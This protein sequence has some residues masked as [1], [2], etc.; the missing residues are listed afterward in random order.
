MSSFSPGS[1][2]VEAREH[3]RVLVDGVLAK[4]RAGVLP[5]LAERE[6]VDCKEEAGRRGRGGSLLVGEPHNQE[7]ARQLANEVTCMANTPGG[8]ALLVGVEDRTGQLLGAGLDAEWLRHRVYEHVGVASAVEERRVEGVRLLVLYVAEARE[9]VEDLNGRIRWRT[10]GHCVGVDRA[11][12]WLHR[13]LSAGHDPMAQVTQRTEADVSPGA[14]AVA[15]RYLA[16]GDADAA[17]EIGGT[18]G[19]LLRSLGV[20]R[21]DG[22]LTAAGA[23]TFC[24]A[25]RTHISLSVW[26]VEGGELLSAPRQMVGLSLLEQI[27]LVDERLDT[28][29]KAVRLT[30]GPGFAQ[31]YVR[32]LPPG[33]VREAVLNGVVHRDWMQ[34]D[35]VAVTWIEE[36]SAIEV[37]SPGGFAGG[38]TSDTALTQRY[39]RYPALADLFRALRLVEKQGLGVDRMYR[40]MVVLGHRPP[41]LREEAGPRVRVR[42]VG[43]SPVVPVMN[44]MAGIRPEVR[45]RDVKVALIVHTLLHEPF[46]TALHLTRILQ[47]GEAEAAEALEVAA[48]CVVGEASLIKRY[49]D[50][51]VL[52]DEAVS[53]VDESAGNEVLRR[54]GVLSYVRPDLAGAEDVARRWLASHDRYSSGDH[55][56][57]T[58]LTYTGARG[59]LERLER[60]GLLLRGEGS[61]RSAHFIAGPA[62]QPTGRSPRDG[63]G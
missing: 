32:Q 10:G 51:W 21:P 34:S 50:V 61:G 59:Q 38:I 4:L 49:K 37:V 54:R 26:D 35:P 28:L 63:D 11:E 25:D 8:G 15:R 18:T 31:N 1:D 5:T 30:A 53:V 52:T 29:N 20:L 42:L 62:L 48:D 3:L 39:A 22:R 57:L 60:A 13:Q 44:L 19:D 23:L 2:L 36:D 7:A 14:V 43:G 41:L 33:A 45:Q 56:A 6:K 47:R 46:T 40:D 9:P 16:A 12:W 58:G 17:A 24:P 27:A 55:S